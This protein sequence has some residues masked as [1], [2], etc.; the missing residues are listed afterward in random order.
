MHHTFDEVPD[1]ANLDFQ[2]SRLDVHTNSSAV[3][4]FPDHISNATYVHTANKVDTSQHRQ[5]GYK[6]GSIAIGPG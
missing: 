6:V 2:A 5:R 3:G 4:T 1:D